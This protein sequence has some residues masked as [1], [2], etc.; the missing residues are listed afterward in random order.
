MSQQTE[1][2]NG[3]FQKTKSVRSIIKYVK[4]FDREEAI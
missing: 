2:A 4:S 3:Y 1:I